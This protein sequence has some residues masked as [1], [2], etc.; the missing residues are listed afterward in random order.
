MRQFGESMHFNGMSLFLA[1]IPQGTQLYR[2]TSLP[3]PVTHLQWLAFEPEHALAVVHAL[4][5]P[6]VKQYLHTYHTMR[7][8]QM[9]YIDGQSAAKTTKGV[10]DVQDLIIRDPTKAPKPP[11]P[12]S[13]PPGAL[14][15]S[16]RAEEMCHLAE[17][18]WKGK[19][20]GFIRMQGGFEVI[21]CS[22]VRKLRVIT[23]KALSTQAKVDEL[24][25][26][27]AVAARFDGIGDHR[28]SLDFDRMVSMYAYG[29]L[30]YIDKQGFPRVNNRTTWLSMAK[31]DLTKMTTSFHF[32]SGHDWQSIM[33]MYVSRYSDKIQNFASGHVKDFNRMLE[34]VDAT[35]EAFID[36]SRR[37]TKRETKDCAEQ[38]W[39][40]DLTS[41]FVCPTRLSVAAQASR[42]VAYRICTTFLTVEKM[43]DPR[44]AISAFRKLKKWLDWATFKRCRGCAVDAMC[45]APIWPLGTKQDYEQPECRK[46]LEGLVGGKDSFWTEP[47]DTSR[48]LGLP[49]S[50]SACLSSL[51][52]N[53]HDNLSDTSRLTIDPRPQ[54]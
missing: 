41:I 52:Q 47:T 18:T 14:G 16:E 8:L 25:Y 39:P 26:Y 3:H 40:V 31:T 2:G 38:F 12:G 36:Y 15:D 10:F 27:K 5:K 28:V 50:A 21:L 43:K 1:Q 53:I 19:I 23:I 20:D 42:L 32:S 22:A 29:D 48:P 44:K 37:D 17:T 13:L 4:S 7:P 11:P 9:V 46:S 6:G 33:D 34:I 51:L 45:V 54:Q 35:L 24:N 30:V 49:A